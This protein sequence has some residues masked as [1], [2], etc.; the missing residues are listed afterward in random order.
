M[1]FNLRGIMLRAWNIKKQDKNNYFPLCLKMAWAEAKNQNI[2]LPE[3]IGSPKQIKWAEDI[4]REYIKFFET[5]LEGKA[6]FRPMNIM[7]AAGGI[8]FRN[9]VLNKVK[10]AWVWID[11]RKN[12]YSFF[13]V[14]FVK[15][16]GYQKACEICPYLGKDTDKNYYTSLMKKAGF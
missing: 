9:F 1:K 14:A 8:A 3:L 11:D 12:Y 4:R 13:E 2:E 5:A 15:F 6:P 16:M 7:A 10:K